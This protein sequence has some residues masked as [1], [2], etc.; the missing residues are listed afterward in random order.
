MSHQPAAFRC[1]IMWDEVVHPGLLV[2]VRQRVP[3]LAAH[4]TLDLD[5]AM[6][7]LSSGLYQAAVIDIDHFG[8]ADGAYLNLARRHAPRLKVLGLSRRVSD[9]E[10]HAVEGARWLALVSPA[11]LPTRLEACWREFRAASESGR[12]AP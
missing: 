7:R 9:T 5:D 12:G 3:L 2:A 4:R 8:S 11:A 10:V 1:V 6:F